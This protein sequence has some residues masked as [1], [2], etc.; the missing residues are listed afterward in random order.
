[1]RDKED[2]R[3][4]GPVITLRGEKVGL[5]PIRRE[6][7]VVFIKWLND[8]EV[9]RNLGMLSRAGRITAEDEERWFDRYAHDKDSVTFGIYELASNRLIGDCGLSG[10]DYVQRTA[11]FGILI[12]AK[13]CWNKGFGTEA[14]MLTLDYGFNI[15]GL[16]NI[17]LTV[18]AHNLRGLLAYEKAGFKVFG[19]RREA[20][21]VAGEVSDV[22]YMDVLAS[23][24]Q[25]PVLKNLLKP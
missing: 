8:P 20:R 18:Y 16:H 3:L 21:R 4:N 2:R 13:D 11:E 12:G 24:F 25:S 22:V 19:R 17:M 15:L 7:A 10:V 9:T 1:M 23:E 6:D 5:G 14:T